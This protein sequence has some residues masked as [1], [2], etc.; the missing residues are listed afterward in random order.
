MR[1]QYGSWFEMLWELSELTTEEST[2]VRDNSPLL[3]EVEIAPMTRSYKMVL[4]EAFQELNGWRNGPALPVL[5]ARSWQVLSRRRQFLADL[6]ASFQNPQAEL[7]EE[8]GR[9]WRK[10]PVD[11][12]IGANRG[13]GSAFFALT[14]GCFVSKTTVAAEQIGS[15]Q[16]LVQQ[17]ID[18]R[19][20]TYEHRQAAAPA[21]NVI[22]FVRP[23]RRGIEVPFFPNIRIACGHFKTGSADAE[24]FRALGEEHGKLDPQRHFIVRASGHSMDGGKNPIRDGDYLLLERL[25]PGNAG[26]ITGSVMAIERQ[27]ES[28]DNQYLLRVVLKSPSGGYVLHANN[29]DYAD[30]EATDDMR[31]L[32]KLREVLDPFELATGQA[33]LREDIPPLFGLTFNQGLWNVGHVVLRDQKAHVLLVT[34]NKQGKSDDHKYLDHWLDENTFHWQTQNATT[35]ESAKGRSIIG[36][37]KNGWQIH[38]FVRETKL[39][40]GTAAPF[41]YHGTANYVRHEGSAPMSVTLALQ[42]EVGDH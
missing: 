4:L 11:A 33:F 17:L 26:S 42:S 34:L 12:W 40:Q 19:F 9:Y 29:P 39:N 22:P 37:Q 3:R 8:W 31:T 13:D 10:N 30:M 24:E 25:S 2:A 5:A 27:D 28:G 32:A 1:R 41:M 36:H 21:S 14:E 23:A 16:E 6:P 18:F 7:S 35:P 38:L 15:L 20:A